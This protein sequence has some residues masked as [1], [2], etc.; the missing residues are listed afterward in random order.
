M[1]ISGVFLMLP[2]PRR[3]PPSGS[4]W[5][6]R[7]SESMLS[8]YAEAPLEVESFLAQHR[9]L[10]HRAAAFLAISDERRHAGPRPRYR[11]SGCSQGHLGAF[12]CRVA[13]TSDS[14]D[15]AGTA[16]IL[17]FS[18]LISSMPDALRKDTEGAFAELGEPAPRRP[19]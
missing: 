9:S 6:T 2:S 17:P 13:N 19:Q 8:G 12:W 1:T 10:L 14:L 11:R 5:K 18:G 15:I 16:V 3:Q 4:Q 7:L